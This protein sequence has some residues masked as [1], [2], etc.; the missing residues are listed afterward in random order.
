[1]HVTYIYIYTYI[2][3]HTHIYMYIYIKEC[4]PLAWMEYREHCHTALHHCMLYDLAAQCSSCRKTYRQI[5]EA[6]GKH[7]TSWHH[8]LRGLVATSTVGVFA[9]YLWHF[10]N[11]SLGLKARSTWM[12][13]LVTSCYPFC[14]SFSHQPNS[15]R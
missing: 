11:H 9:L 12:L 10:G 14:E 6:N 13:L 5:A 2:H 4:V 3:I 15:P 8:T 1:M 7:G